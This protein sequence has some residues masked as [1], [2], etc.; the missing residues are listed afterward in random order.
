MISSEEDH[1][2]LKSSEEHFRENIL[3]KEINTID[4]VDN[5]EGEGYYILYYRSD[6][7]EEL[8]QKNIW[9]IWWLKENLGWVISQVGY[10]L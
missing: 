5:D 10:S 1:F 7:R 8:E 9:E 3:E 4:V 2:F 6:R